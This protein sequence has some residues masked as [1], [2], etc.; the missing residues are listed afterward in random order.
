VLALIAATGCGGPESTG[1]AGG[2]ET[3]AGTPPDSGWVAIFNGRDLTGWTPK[4]RHSVAGL[5]SLRTF[6]VVDGLLTVSYDDYDTFEGRFGHLFYDRPLSS[7]DLRVEYRIVGE[8]LTGGADWARANSGVMIHSQSPESM[9]PEQDFPISLE[10]Q[11]LRGFGDGPRPTA[12][13]CTPGT[14]VVRDGKLWTPHCLNSSSVTYRGDVWVTVE[15][16]V[17]G[18]EEI[19]HFVEGREVLRYSRPQLDL[20]DPDAI[21]WRPE[22]PKLLEGGSISIQGEGHPVEFRRIEMLPLPPPDSGKAGEPPPR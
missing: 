10:A 22:G 6:R 20:E 5:D 9:P 17:R 19:R 15:I 14:H 1:E 12:N 16:E 8:Q 11:M 21:R 13:L 4:I 7:Y 2:G 3:L 18:S